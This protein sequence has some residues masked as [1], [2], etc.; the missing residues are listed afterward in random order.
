MQRFIHAGAAEFDA[1]FMI[2]P[3]N[4]TY[5]DRMSLRQDGMRE[6]NSGMRLA[7]ATAIPQ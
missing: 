7:C 3:P 4:L 6:G 1:S 5:G 2:F